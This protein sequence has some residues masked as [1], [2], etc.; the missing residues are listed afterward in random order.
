MR[1]VLVVED[2]PN[3]LE[4]IVRFLTISGFAVVSAA[5]GPDGV[6][7]ARNEKPDLILMDM[8]LPNPEDGL[9][10]TRQIRGQGGTRTIPIIAFTAFSMAQDKE[11]ARCAGC[12]DFE[13]KP[14]DFRRLR[15]KIQQCLANNTNTN[16]TTLS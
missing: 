1:K 3:N 7:A 9:E 6:A 12:N 2:D 11:K 8:G 5:N 4:I 16:T 10:A 15:V 14:I 13:S